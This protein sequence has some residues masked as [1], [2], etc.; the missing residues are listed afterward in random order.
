MEQFAVVL[1]EEKSLD[2][3]KSNMPSFNQS[4]VESI[5]IVCRAGMRIREPRNGEVMSL[6]SKNDRQLS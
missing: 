5:S 1:F 6:C 2:F 3:A 4:I